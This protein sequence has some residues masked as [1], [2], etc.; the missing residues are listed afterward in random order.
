MPKFYLKR[1]EIKIPNTKFI[2]IGK[3]QENKTWYTKLLD[4][5]TNK[6]RTI[7]KEVSKHILKILASAC[8]NTE[9]N[10]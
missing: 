8:Y 5:K 7:K 9:L 3:E 1:I 10:I 2:M 6:K 4:P